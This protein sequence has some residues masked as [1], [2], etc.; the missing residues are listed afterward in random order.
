[1]G[2][3]EQRILPKGRRTVK[4]RFAIFLVAAFVSTFG[5]TACGGVAEKEVQEA[6]EQVEQQVQEAREQVEQEVQE[7]QQ[8]IEQEA[9][10]AQQ[11]IEQEAQNA[12]QQIEEKVE[13]Q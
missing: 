7:G 10:D 2:S 9:Q 13:G 8:Q 4:R 5:A 12:Q 11:Q 3:S 6:Q 1:M